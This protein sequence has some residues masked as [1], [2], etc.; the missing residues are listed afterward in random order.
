MTKI[1]EEQLREHMNM[2]V[3]NMFAVPLMFHMVDR[4]ISDEL[5]DIF[6]EGISEG[7]KEFDL[8]ENESFMEE[9]ESLRDNFY[10]ISRL[11]YNPE[12]FRHILIDYSKKRS[13][14]IH[15]GPHG[16]T[17]MYFLRASPNCGSVVF[18]NPNPHLEYAYMNTDYSNQEIQAPNVFQMPSMSISPVKGLFIM[19]PSYLQFEIEEIEEDIPRT[20]FHFTYG[21]NHTS[22]NYK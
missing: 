22:T 9:L 5:E 14:F 3:E 10:N 11:E 17:G 20:F 7:K 18:K 2:R 19:F 6:L 12:D 16:I 4:S 15:N 21:G 13:P 1:T 8:I